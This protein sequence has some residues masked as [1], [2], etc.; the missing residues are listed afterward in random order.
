M[1]NPI[2]VLPIRLFCDLA[3]RNQA[4]VDLS[5]GQAPLFYRG[6][7][8]EIDIGIGAAGALLTPS[9]SNITSVT[10]QLFVGEN[11]TGAAMMSCTV[12]AAAMNLALTA[13]QWTN[14]TTPFFHAA[15]VF[16]NTATAVPLNGAASANYWL[17]ITLATADT[18]PKQITLLSGAITVLDGP[19]ATSSPAGMSHARFATVAGRQ[20]LQILNDSDGKFYTVGIEND[21]GAPALYLGDTGY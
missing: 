8:V 19:I 16:P 3:A 15:F 2:T 20:V 6:D 18:A 11:D 7:D 5:T 1:S 14:E 10:C 21:N 4:L 9:L 17:R 13:A 12:P